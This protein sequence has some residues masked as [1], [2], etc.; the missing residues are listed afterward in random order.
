MYLR[1]DVPLWTLLPLPEAVKTRGMLGLLYASGQFL[2]ATRNWVARKC[3]SLVFVGMKGSA[4]DG[5]R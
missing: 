3:V 2:G 4:R 1:P 5:V